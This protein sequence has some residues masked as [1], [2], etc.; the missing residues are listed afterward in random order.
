MRPFGGALGDSVELRIIDHYLS[1]RGA[2]LRAARIT[3]VVIANEEETHIALQH[4][5]H[6]GIL[7]E[8]FGVKK[9]TR[10]K[11]VEGAE[12]VKLLGT[13]ANL[14][15]CVAGRYVPLSWDGK[16]YPAEIV[17]IGHV[18][19][20]GTVFHR[21]RHAWIYLDPDTGMQRCSCELCSKRRGT[22]R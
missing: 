18:E 8:D 2:K 9:W 13:M 16:T 22:R 11:L 6:A 14:I 17:G 4:L 3:Q 12:I 7:Q 10:Y 1:N 20:I 19:V 15:G 5:I 21:R